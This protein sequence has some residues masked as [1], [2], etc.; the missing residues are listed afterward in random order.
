M[1]IGHWS[2]KD[3]IGLMPRFD[4]YFIFTTVLQIV[5]L[6]ILI[7]SFIA[8]IRN[9]KTWVLLKGIVIITIFV[10]ISYILNLDVFIYIINKAGSIAILALLIIFQPELRQALENIGINGTASRIIKLTIR[11]K[12]NGKEK[13]DK[14]LLEIADAA[15]KMGKVKTGAL[16]VIE[17][18][19]NLDNIKATGIKVDG[20]VTAALLINIFEKNTPL[21]DGAVVVTDDRV[22]SATCYLPLSSS[23]AI[24]KDLGTRHRAALGIS[25]VSDA[26]TVV[27]SEETGAVTMALNGNLNRYTKE[28]D[29]YNALKKN[30][31]YGENDKVKTRTLFSI[32]RH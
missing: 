31:L 5:I 3:Y 9:T 12:S 29:L 14:A 2:L 16:I 4:L 25:E 28:E 21:H 15:F 24:S 10:I 11:N 23:I 19:N 32:W 20:I 26:V 17:R 6:S 30:C 22:D 7:Y 13:I 8:W 27:V 1:T 18:A